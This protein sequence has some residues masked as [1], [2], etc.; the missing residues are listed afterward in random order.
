MLIWGWEFYRYEAPEKT[1]AGKN[2]AASRTAMAKARARR[3]DALQQTDCKEE[4]GVDLNLHD[5][6]SSPTHDDQN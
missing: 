3:K 5:K 2:R 4:S 1:I 6:P